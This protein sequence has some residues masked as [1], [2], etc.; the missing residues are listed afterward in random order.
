LIPFSK[1]FI[2]GYKE[3]PDLYG[4]FWVLTTLVANLFISSNLY[5]FFTITQD[6][7]QALAVSFKSIP[8]AATVIYGVAIGLPLLLKLI[9]NLY[10]TAQIARHESHTTIL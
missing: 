4:P 9:I 8:V 7:K 10:G 3:K 6:N 5:C 1:K 2:T